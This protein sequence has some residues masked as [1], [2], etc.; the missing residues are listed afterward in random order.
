VV[1]E[2]SLSSPD[3]AHKF[4]PL[5]VGI[6]FS[7]KLNSG[8]LASVAQVVEYLPPVLMDRISIPAMGLPEKGADHLKRSFLIHFWTVGNEHFECES[9]NSMES[10]FHAS[11][12]IAL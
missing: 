10:D 1:P 6:G 4:V 12:R 7:T 9:R 2:V 11:A 3:M 5:L 8:H